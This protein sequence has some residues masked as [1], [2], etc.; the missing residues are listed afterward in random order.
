MKKLTSLGI[1]FIF[2][3]LVVIAKEN[4]IIGIILLGTGIFLV[5]R[6]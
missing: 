5:S 6:E 4:L 3:G 1:A 2:A